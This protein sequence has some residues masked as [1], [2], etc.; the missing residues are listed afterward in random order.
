M[1]SQAP[2]VRE[3]SYGSRIVVFGYVPWAAKY[4]L[5]R[6]DGQSIH[7][8]PRGT[9][10]IPGRVFLSRVARHEGSSDLVVAIVYGRNDA[11]PVQVAP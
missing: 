7:V 4:V 9:S 5:I 10:G 1:Q 6:L 2:L 11:E 3:A 8:A